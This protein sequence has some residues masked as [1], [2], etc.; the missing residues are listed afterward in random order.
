[1]TDKLDTR[2]CCICDKPT[3]KKKRFEEQTGRFQ[4]EWDTCDSCFRFC[5]GYTDKER[6]VIKALKKVI[7]PYNYWKIE[8]IMIQLRKVVNTEVSV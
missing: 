2:Y 1:M 7:L 8:D 5:V 4:G 6:P 3:V